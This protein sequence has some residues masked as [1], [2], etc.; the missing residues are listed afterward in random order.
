MHI[1]KKKRKIISRMKRSAITKR[2]KQIDAPQ[3]LAMEDDDNDS[4]SDDDKEQSYRRMMYIQ[5]AWPT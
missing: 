2:E 5:T 3:L 4:Y 1:W